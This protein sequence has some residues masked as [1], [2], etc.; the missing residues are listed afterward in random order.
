MTKFRNN[1]KLIKYQ[2][3]FATLILISFTTVAQNWTGFR[4]PGGQGITDESELPVSWN[5][6]TN[7]VWKVEIPGTG[8][9]SPVIWDD[10]VFISTATDSGKVCRVLALNLSTGDIIWN[11]KVFDLSSV[12]MQVKNSYASSTPVTDGQMLYAVFGDGSICAL[13][14][15]GKV[16]WQNREIK[17]YCEHGLGASPLLYNDLVIMPYDG[18]NPG[19]DKNL[20]WQTPWDKA[21]IVAFNKKN[22]EIKWQANRGLSRIA[23][24]TPAIMIIEGKPQLISAAGD[25]VQGFDPENGKRLWSV[26]NPGEGVVP[27]ITTGNGF[28]F[29][30]SGWGDPTIRA[31]CPIKPDSAKIV[32]EMKQDVPKIPSFLYKKPYLYTISEHGIA[33]CIEAET[34]NLVWRERIGGKFSASPIMADDKIYLLDEN[35]KTTVIKVAPDFTVI[36]TNNLSGKCQA[37]MAVAKRN[38]LIRTDKYL[39][40]IKNKLFN[41]EN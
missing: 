34:G 31:I 25:V 39:Y 30:S 23:Y 26:S 2:L 38:I 17:H 35:A 41:S 40:C 11:S 32:W 24:V 3:I 20:G 12:H 22:G 10:L 21:I 37:S 8:W 5:D 16:V 28:V 36:A 27:S 14:F 4:G 29:T 7:I 18:S 33:M 13:N 19:P 6:S 15:E 9:S 1:K